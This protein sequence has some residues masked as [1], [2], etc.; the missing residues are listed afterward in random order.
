MRKNLLEKRKGKNCRLVVL[1]LLCLLL[2]NRAVLAEDWDV[3]YTTDLKSV[4]ANTYGAAPMPVGVFYYDGYLYV[5]QET[6]TG[7]PWSQI[8]ERGKLYKLKQEAG[9]WVLDNTLVIPGITTGNVNFTDFEVVGNTLYAVNRNKNIYQIDLTTMQQI[10][11]PIVTTLSQ[12]MAIAYDPVKDAFWVVDNND[13]SRVK[14]VSRTGQLVT[15]QTALHAYSGS[16]IPVVG[17]AYDNTTEGGPYL[18][19][20]C[21]YMAYT[22]ISAIS[23]W[24]ISTGVYE[25]SIKD[26]STL[27]GAVTYSNYMGGLF[28]YA[29]PKLGKQVLCGISRQTSLLYGYEFATLADPAAP[30]AV[31]NYTVL[32]GADGSLQARLSWNN[33]TMTVGGESLNAIDGVKILRNDVLVNT[34]NNPSPGTDSNWIDNSVTAGITSYKLV[35]YNSAGDGFATTVRLFIGP[36]VPAAIGDLTLSKE[37]NNAKLNW[38]APTIGVN[39]G[40][41]HTAS[42]KYTITRF[43]D[44]IEVAKNISV[45]SFTDNSIPEI[46][47]YYYKVRVSN[48]AG[49]GATS[50]SNSMV[51]GPALTTPFRED[52]DNTANLTLWTIIAN[53]GNANSWVYQSYGGYTT[54]YCMRCPY[55]NSINRNDWLITPPIHLDAGKTYRISWADKSNSS[56]NAE[57]YKM[58]YGAAATVEGQ[59]NELYSAELAKTSWSERQAIVTNLTA[60]GDFYFSWHCYSNAGN[61]GLFIDDVLVEELVSIDLL[62]A[63]ISGPKSLSVGTEAKHTLTVTNNGFEVVNSFT[64]TLVDESD[65]LLATVTYSGE[66]LASGASTDVSFKWTPTKEGEHTITAKVQVANDSDD[67]NNS[68]S[69]DVNTLP[70]GV[71]ELLIG[72]GNGTNN[73]I[74]FYFQMK[75]SVS[76]V[77]YFADEIGVTGRIDSLSLS[78]TFSSAMNREVMIMMSE[79]EQ[80]AIEGNKWI[81]D[82]LKVVYEGY[83]YFKS[84][85]NDIMI[86]LN[87]PYSYTGKNLVVTFVAPTSET[88]SYGANFYVTSTDRPNRSVQRYTAGSPIIEFTE[89]GSS[90]VFSS[91]GGISSSDN[92]PNTRFFMN[93]DVGVL[94]GTVSDDVQV[95]KGALVEIENTGL[96]GLTDANGKYTIHGI[97]SGEYT[98]KVTKTGYGVESKSATITKGNVS[99]VDF[100]IHSLLNIKLEGLVKNAIGEALPNAAVIISG[101]DDHQVVTNENGAFVVENIFAS[102]TY[103]ITVR[104]G[105]YVTHRADL[106]SDDEDMSLNVVMEGCNFMPPRD[107]IANKSNDDWYGVEMSWTAPLV[108]VPEGYNIYV[109]GMLVNAEP[110][111]T[112]SF[113]YILPGANSYLLEVASVWSTGCEMR[114]GQTL[115][116]E[117]HP[118]EEAIDQ[119]PHVESF[120]AEAFGDCWTQ[121]RQFGQSS[122]NVLT[123]IS[124]YYPTVY[125]GNY[126][127]SIRG[128]NYGMTRLI[129]PLLDLSE[130]ETP[131]LNL[132]YITPVPGGGTVYDKL[133]IYSRSNPDAEWTL[134][135]E[136]FGTEIWSE[137]AIDLPN[138]SATYQIAFEGEIQVGLGV[139]IDAVRVLDDLCNPVENLKVEQIAERSVTLSWDAPT[140]TRIMAYEIFRDNVSLGETVE[141]TYVD[142]DISIGNHTWK[143]VVLYDKSYCE[144][145]DAKTVTA[146]TEEMCDPIDNL[147]ATVLAPMQVELTWEAVNASKLK[148]YTILRNDRVV[149]VDVQTAEYVD[150]NVPEG[151]YTYCVKAVYQDKVCN[152]SE[153]IYKEIIVNCGAVENLNAEVAHGAI[154]RVT[155]EVNVPGYEYKGVIANFVVYRDG[156]RVGEVRAHEYTDRDI[157][158]GQSYVYSVIPYYDNGCEGEEAFVTMEYTCSVPADLSVE[159]T[160]D[161]DNNC[162]AELSWRDPR[163]SLVAGQPEALPRENSDLELLFDNGPFV[164]HQN[165]GYEGA[166]ISALTDEHDTMGYIVDRGWNPPFSHTDDFILTEDS[167]IAEIDFFPYMSN[168]TLEMNFLFESLYIVI[169]EG[170]PAQ[171]GR[172]VWGDMWENVLKD[173][174]FTGVYRTGPEEDH[175]NNTRPIIRVTG[176]V[177]ET[178]PAGEYWVEWTCL[179]YGYNVGGPWVCPVAIPGQLH[180]G[181]AWFCS[182]GEW[183]QMQD[184]KS[185]GYFGFPFLVYGEEVKHSH[186]VYRDDKLIASD[187]KERSFTDTGVTNGE[188]T[189]RVVRLCGGEESGSASFTLDVDCVNSMDNIDDSQLKVHPNPVSNILFIEK[190][191]L[192]NRVQLFDLSGRLL[193]QQEV[194]DDS[195]SQIDMSKFDKGAYIL[196]VDG[197]EIKVMKH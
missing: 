197:R 62:A 190:S 65:D 91:A 115:T 104:A 6:V 168:S 167:Y 147:Q 185:K 72:T 148:G 126:Y 49:D 33:P 127:A 183:F 14:L 37:G 128:N 11:E 178:F 119:F 171:G 52:F 101:Y 150:E 106:I 28:S 149:A 165:A 116:Y 45:T 74:P 107:L 82:D 133:R 112:L 19:A 173:F 136:A 24:N 36:D 7:D 140:T 138:P 122:W 145:S 43:P 159:I 84:G 177:G 180:T 17:L 16:N 141:T 27:P 78:N 161:K 162:V 61:S 31:S 118:C 111:K 166:P 152:E 35:P 71:H 163:P 66:G 144:K 48:N 124:D 181:N 187:L 32:P 114:I 22:N 81:Q 76:Q 60:S 123:Q 1:T 186:N 174:Q 110:I 139:Y 160:N 59:T 100:T 51:I 120:E 10:G 192:I 194:G 26:T 137:I 188:H 42:L 89:D 77:I 68:T 156:K 58:Y 151:F 193:Q 134:L 170:N 157:E 99:N 4:L 73:A 69:L 53:G 96:S 90:Y 169:W 92:V 57:K 132:W 70:Y 8:N 143:V 105:G 103:Q 9:S 102:R 155:W 135:Y 63:S 121:E 97:P 195:R 109:N 12:V 83:V 25:H 153:S 189:W 40:W 117:Q 158:A 85:Q 86:R 54:N 39:G 67:E 88:T 47:N 142:S 172:V 184:S 130:L 179:A 108:K 94:E 44:E 15:G 154:A 95:V 164:T 41:I 18:V 46:N 29:D 5:S 13:S 79:T 64:A 75:H 196:K 23:R 131:G 175:G 93:S 87:K 20:S 191:D 21:G 34:I 98:V 3:L 2:N 125:D 113:S 129:T 182:Y 176:T 146:T 30:A 56:S 38:T 55:D 80:D 50:I